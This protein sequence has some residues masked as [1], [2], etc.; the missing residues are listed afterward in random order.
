[1][2]RIQSQDYEG[3]PA[4][5][6]HATTKKHHGDYIIREGVILTWE[7]L[8]AQNKTN[9]LLRQLVAPA[10]APEVEVEVENPEVAPA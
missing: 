3:R 5:Y 4:A 6:D 2:A 1:M 9:S 8:Q 10:E 7:L